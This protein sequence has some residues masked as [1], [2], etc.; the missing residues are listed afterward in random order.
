MTGAVIVTTPQD[1]ALLDARK[2]LKMFEKVNVPVLG[3]IENMSVY[4][5]P[6]CGHEAPIFGAGGGHRMCQDYDVDF[7]GSLPLD[8]RIREQADAG[9]PIVAADR[10]SH[11]ALNYRD[12]ACYIAAK[13]SEMPIDHSTKI[14][15]IV[16][17]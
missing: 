3:L 13:I 11:L 9:C 12:I 4:H 14:P 5:C 16:A 10:D 17:I 2:A 8:I 7:L 15:K 1:I 6:Q